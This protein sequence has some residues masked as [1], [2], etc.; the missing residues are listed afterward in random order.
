MYV[1]KYLDRGQITSVVWEI[2]KVSVTVL[3]N[4]Q[5]FSYQSQEKLKIFTNAQIINSEKKN[6]FQEVEQTFCKL[7]HSIY[8]GT[9]ND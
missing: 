6:L 8:L 3:S 7:G 4:E 1:L 5:I 9:F 2:R